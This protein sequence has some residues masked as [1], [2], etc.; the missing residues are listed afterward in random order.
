MVA[1][2]FLALN[3]YPIDLQTS[4][5]TW[6]SRDTEQHHKYLL[7]ELYLASIPTSC[8]P[9]LKKQAEKGRNFWTVVNNNGCS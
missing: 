7:S 3:L 2:L 6:A 5:S 1:D 4:E 8:P 9:F